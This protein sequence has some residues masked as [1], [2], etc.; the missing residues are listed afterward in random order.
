MINKKNIKNL[1]IAWIY[2]SGEPQD[3]QCNPIVIDGIIYT[4]ISGNY[5]AAIN[6][7][8]GKVIWKSK[9]F[10]SSLAK[11][12]L[13][14]WKNKETGEERIFFS[15]QKKNLISLNAKDGSFDKKF[16]FNGVVR[17]GLN[18]VPP[19]I[20]KNQIIIPTLDKNIEVYNLIN[21]KLEWK[22]E[23]RKKIKK[24]LVE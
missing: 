22:F 19:A 3:I 13:I 10:K 21:G 23:Y 4:P 24:E 15:N 17:T 16:G 12:G 14:Y 9:K 7:Y 1:K 8:D 18:L 20:Y 6:G 5:I 11:R 2:N